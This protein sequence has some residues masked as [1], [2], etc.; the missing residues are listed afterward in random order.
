[1]RFD[2]PATRKTDH[3]DTYFDVQVA[4]PYRW[5]EDDNSSETMAW[6]EAQNTLTFSYLD[7]FPYRGQV[8]DRLKA[9]LNYARYS[10][11]F[12]KHDDI[13]YFKND[14]LQNQSVLWVQKGYD[15]EPEI[16]LDP[17]AFSDDGT[18]RLTFFVLSKDGRYAV[19]GKTAISGSDW[20]DLYVMDM[21]SRQTLPEI[22]RWVRYSGVAWAGDGFYYSRYPEPE[23][24]KE[25]TALNE[26]QKV[27]FHKVGTS[28]SDDTLVYEDTAHPTYAIGL[29]TTED[30]RF[31]VLSVRDPNKR[32]N[33]LY[34]CDASLDETVFRAVVNEI[35]EDQYA[36]IDHIDGKL[37]VYS[38]HN[39]PNWKVV[40]VDTS[41]PSEANWKTFLPEAPDRLD[42]V[43]MAGGKL[44]A[45]YLKDVCSHT[46]V[47]GRDGH[48][49]NEV[50]LPGSGTV[51]GFDGEQQDEEVFYSFTSLNYPPTIFR[52]EIATGRSTLFRTPSIP[53]FAPEEYESK[54]VFF[55]S[56]DSTRVPMFLVYRKGLALDGTNPTILYG[57]GG[58]DVSILPQFSPSRIAWLEQG[59]IFAIANLRGGGEYGKQW[60]EAGT[61]LNKQN[62]FDDCIAA[63][64]YLIHERYTSASVLA[65]QGGSNGGLLVGAVINQR[66][67]LFKV[68]LPAVGVMDMLR[69]Q[70]FSAGVFWVPDYGKSDDET[71]FHYLLGYSPLHNI[72]PGVTYPAILVTTA[73]HDDRV[74]PAHSFKY[75]ATLQEYTSKQSPALIRVQTNSGHGASNLAKSLE[76]IADQFTFAWGNIGR[77]PSYPA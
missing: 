25:L 44:F 15:G 20:T 71:Q 24:G 16:L 60:H 61:K 6:V 51:R 42:Q 45:T 75:T 52:Y 55:T 53:G 22:I 29:Q 54:Q 50:E 13:F 9:L 73:D 10:V 3:V 43:S 4:D 48:L 27:Y 63:A 1:M 58:F 62:V 49:E 17:N 32:G 11:P 8:L 70:K 26:N 19:Y 40:L 65:L 28:Q 38:D 34:V 74:V 68:A 5:L 2:Y 56:K 36:V 69:F 33:A 47:I 31:A 59:G 30:E 23:K 64:E 35:G 41:Y 67:D 12:K 66:P 77:P 18:I 57:Y 39:A 21:S 46:L 37:L 76:E 14:G 7:Q 72:Q